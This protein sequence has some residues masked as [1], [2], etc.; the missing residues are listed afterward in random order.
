M[1]TAV[2]ALL[3]LGKVMAFPADCPNVTVLHDVVGDNWYDGC[4]GLQ[5]KPLATTAAACEEQCKTDMNCSIW[6]MTKKACWSGNVVH[7]CR[8]RGSDV[9]LGNFEEDLVAGQRLQHGFIKVISTNDF[10]T[11][12][13]K[14]YPE[15]TGTQAEQ[16]ERCKQFCYTDVTCT[17]W[18]YGSDGCWVEHLPGFGKDATKPG[19]EWSKGMIAGE[20]IEHTCPPYVPPESNIWPWVIGGIVAALL[21]LAALAYF[22]QKKPKVKKTRAVKIEP[23]KDPPVI[24]YIPQPTVLIPMSQPSMVMQPTYTTQQVTQAAPTYT[25]QTVQTYASAAP[26]YTTAVPAAQPLMTTGVPAL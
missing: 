19:S 22:L 11:M 4:L 8:S 20:T 17:V 16:V 2:A 21:A 24:T 12:G 6:Q 10:E 7:G 9:A 26:A 3:V 18:Q 15:K 23:K 25:T 14:H 13:L 5:N 1:K